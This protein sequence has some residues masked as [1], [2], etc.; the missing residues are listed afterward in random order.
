LLLGG[1]CVERRDR[2]AETNDTVEEVFYLSHKTAGLYRYE[3][4]ARR[5]AGGSD[6]RQ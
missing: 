4:R 6:H 5:P 1:K 3:V 2:Q